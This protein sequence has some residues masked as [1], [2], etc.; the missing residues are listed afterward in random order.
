MCSAACGNLGTLPDGSRIADPNVPPEIWRNLEKQ[1]N[2]EA[3]NQAA[4]DALPYAIRRRRLWAGLAAAIVLIIVPIALVV[5]HSDSSDREHAKVAM[6]FG[7]LPR[8]V[9]SES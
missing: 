4:P 5:W 6:S 9:H 7:A 1:L 2:T 3:R 8:R